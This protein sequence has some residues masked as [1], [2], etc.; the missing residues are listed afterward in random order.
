MPFY[1]RVGIT[2]EESEFFVSDFR[3]TG[4]IERSV[5]FINL[6]NDYGLDTIELGNCIS[7]AMEAS[8][9]G[10]IPE[11]LEWGNPDQMIDL[12]NK[13]GRR[14]GIGD[15][16]AEGGWRAAKAFGNEGLANQVKG[17]CI[18]AYDPRGIKGHGLGY[19]T[20][21]RGGCHLRAY[22]IAPEVLDALTTNW[23]SGPDVSKSPSCI[24]IYR[25]FPGHAHKESRK[26]RRNYSSKSRQQI[27]GRQDNR[28]WLCSFSGTGPAA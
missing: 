12:V 18:P 22:M 24:S 25:H 5:L 7:I 27:A 28:L 13:I 21:N 9:R 20:S 11:K 8:Q 3:R 15:K 26:Q 4:A 2:F 6:A 1:Y 23:A 16:L 14:E 19:A 10:L 17:Q